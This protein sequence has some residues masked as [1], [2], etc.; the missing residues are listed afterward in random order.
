MYAPAIL[1]K[2]NC[3]DE[4]MSY[5]LN[6]IV[7]SCNCANKDKMFKNNS[8]WAIRF[9]INPFTVFVLKA[10]SMYSESCFW[11]FKLETALS[12]YILDFIIWH[13]NWTV[14]DFVETFVFCWFSF[15]L[16]PFSLFCPTPCVDGLCGEKTIVQFYC[17]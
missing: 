15:Y 8:S 2:Q 6:A 9:N 11:D 10:W 5:S 16:P 17:H 12:F 3:N 13:N 4:Y 1:L 14:K 7:N